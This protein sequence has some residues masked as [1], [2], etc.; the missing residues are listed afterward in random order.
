MSITLKFKKL[1]ENAT[2]PTRAYGYGNCWDVYAAETKEIH[3]FESTIVPTDLA[4]EVPQGYQL[5]VYNRSSNPLKNKLIL[6][7]SCGIVDTNYRGNL[8]CLFHTLPRQEDLHHGNPTMLPEYFLT[9]NPVM[10]HKND[11]IAQ[12]KL[13][14]IQ[15]EDIEEVA[16]LSETERGENGFGSSSL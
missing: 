6:S 12:I 13:V 3:S 8:G 5:H 4:F 2:T 16:E 14:P 7:N 15:N 9:D 11:K 1:S 10:I